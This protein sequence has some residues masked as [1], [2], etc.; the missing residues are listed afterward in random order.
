MAQVNRS[1]KVYDVCIVGSGAAGGTAAKILTEG[2]LSVAMLEAGRALNPEVDFKEHVW[3]YELAHRGAGVGGHAL[4]PGNGMENEF[5]APTAPGLSKASLTPPRP[6]RIFRW[7]RSRI[8]GG[9]TNHWGRIALRFA[10]V[11]FSPNARWRGRRLA[12]HV[13][14]NRALLR[15]GRILHRRIR[16]KEE[17]SQCARRH[18]PAA[19]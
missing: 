11:D 2:G 14:R 19:T 17:Y 5:I 12:H 8:V 18:L 10:P 1:P 6:D 13:R 16:I 9:R 3:P 4:E 15:Q 7:Y